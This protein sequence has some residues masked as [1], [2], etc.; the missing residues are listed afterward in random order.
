MAVSLEL[1]PPILDHELVAWGVA[2]PPAL[3]LA[4]GVGKQVLRRAL[5]P[6]LPEELL[7]GRKRGFADAIG[8]QF[9]SR[10]ETVRA[11]LLGGPMLD[12]GLFD[13]A[14]L[15]R[16]A[17]EHASGRF[18]H[19]Q[20]LWQLLVFEGWLSAEAGVTAPLPDALAQAG[21]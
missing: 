16:L 13:A 7:W 19:A 11:R 5:A 17:D 4:G 21:A 2:L 1:R 3:K 15:A 10:A 9:R 18:D 12:A 6:E 14:T 8:A 20:A